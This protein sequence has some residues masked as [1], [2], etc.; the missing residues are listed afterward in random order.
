MGSRHIRRP[1][2]IATVLTVL[3]AVTCESPQPP[4][5]CGPIPQVTVNAKETT[6]VT[7]CFNTSMTRTGIR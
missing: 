6:A 5:A 7:A 1:G 2:A 3:G 4:A